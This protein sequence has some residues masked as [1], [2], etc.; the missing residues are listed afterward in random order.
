MNQLFHIFHL[1]RM[2]ARRNSVPFGVVEGR[3]PRASPFEREEAPCPTAADQDAELASLIST[4]SP[5]SKRMPSFHFI[6]DDGSRRPER[7]GSH[8]AAAAW[9]AESAE[10]LVRGFGSMGMGKRRGAPSAPA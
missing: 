5:V 7:L 8:G 1:E 3:G 4:V 9:G 6:T 10:L 2:R